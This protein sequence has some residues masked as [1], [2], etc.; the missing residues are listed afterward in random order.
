MQTYI[1]YCMRQ[2]N[3][4]SRQSMIYAKYNWQPHVL[5]ID[6]W[7]FFV[8]FLKSKTLPMNKCIKLAPQVCGPPTIT[9]H[10]GSFA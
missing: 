9:K 2:V 3:N 8:Y 7:Y 1:A 6:K 4:C 5:T 10:I